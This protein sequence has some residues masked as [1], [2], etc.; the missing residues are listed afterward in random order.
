MACSDTGCDLLFSIS[1]C[2][3]AISRPRSRANLRCLLWP[4]QQLVQ[5]TKIPIKTPNTNNAQSG[6]LIERTGVSDVKGSRESLV[7]C[8]FA[9]AKAMT[10]MATGRPRTHRKMRRNELRL[11]VKT[12]AE[13]LASLEERNTLWRHINAFA[14]AWIAAHA[15]IAFLH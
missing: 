7:H 2:N 15:A 5:P 1:F 13:F 4:S 3:K 10:R 11:I 6:M 14:G 9:I 8:R 12:G